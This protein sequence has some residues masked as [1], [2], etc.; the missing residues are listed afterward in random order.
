MGDYHNGRLI[1][2]Q[3]RAGERQD[4]EFFHHAHQSILITKFAV[5]ATI[6]MPYTVANEASLL[7]SVNSL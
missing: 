1:P 4:S 5:K 7:F 6:T 3:A 2:A